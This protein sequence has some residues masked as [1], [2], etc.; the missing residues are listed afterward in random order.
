ML[1]GAHA[2]HITD[3]LLRSS[4]WVALVA[5][6]PVDGDEAPARTSLTSAIV[7]L[8]IKDA[9]GD[10]GAAPT[11]FS[12]DVAFAHYFGTLVVPITTIKWNQLNV[13]LSMNSLFAGE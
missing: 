8:R 9:M 13:S 11:D 10:D 12:F 5:L 2:C 7:E 6:Q 1:V 4:S 3:E